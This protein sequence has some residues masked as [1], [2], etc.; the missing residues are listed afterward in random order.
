MAV[1]ITENMPGRG[2]A[3]RANFTRTFGRIFQATTD[4]PHIGSF[5]VRAAFS[6]ATG[7]QIG[8][9]YSIGVDGVDAWFE[10]DT[11]AYCVNIDAQCTSGDGLTW[12]IVVEYGPWEEV[13]EN[14]LDADEEIEWGFAQFERVVDFD[15]DGD[16]I[17]NSAG[18]PFDP[19]VTADDSRPVLSI[20]R[21]EATF[22]AGLADDYRDTVNDATFFG[23]AAGT[24]KCTAITGKRLF[25]ASIGY[26]W[27]IHYEFHFNR[28]GWSKTL[29]D[30]GYIQIVG[31]VRQQI[32]VSGAQPPE[33]MLLN[34]AGGLMAVG[35]TP[36]GL[37]FDIYPEADY[38]V[39]AFTGA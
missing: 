16:A 35:G 27:Q 37:T 34:G 30:R 21:N 28:D 19:S 32:L 39:F 3:H 26:Y 7:V 18:D 36:T 24:V 23:A 6:A 17:V 22:S 5:A 13:P 8:S 31:G 14:P 20:T 29:L 4:D 11:G 9:I 15:R 12:Q 38:T 1:T 25:D 2:S 33:P 10:E